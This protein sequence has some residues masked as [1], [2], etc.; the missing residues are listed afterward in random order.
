MFPMLSFVC[1]SQRKLVWKW[2][3]VKVKW[4]ESISLSSPPLCRLQTERVSPAWRRTREE[5]P[6]LRPQ[7]FSWC[8]PAQT[9]GSP[10][11][12]AGIYPGIPDPGRSGAV[13][14]GHHIQVTVY[15]NSEVPWYQR[16]LFLTNKNLYG[17]HQYFCVLWKQNF[18]YVQI[19]LYF[20]LTFDRNHF[21]SHIYT[22]AYYMLGNFICPITVK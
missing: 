1:W 4:E 21:N 10:A 14:T 9:P 11:E 18:F 6:A 22:S 13:N 17:W 16:M 12:A 20:K 2:R 3:K 15:R 5:P 7:S 8:C 19:E